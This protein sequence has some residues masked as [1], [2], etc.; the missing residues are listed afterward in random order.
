MDTRVKARLFEPFF[1]TK[2]VGKGT[3]LGL[4]SVYGTMKSHNGSISVYSEVGQGTAFNLY[5][6]FVANPSVDSIGVTQ[7][8]VH[9]TG[10]ILVID[11]ESV[12]RSAATDILTELGY[13]VET[14]SDGLDG[15]RNYKDG[16][17]KYDLVILDIIMP[18]LNGS[19]TF[20]ELKK[21]NPNIKALICSGY[22]MNAVAARI[23]E[24][25]AKSFIQ[26]PFDV[27]K[28][29]KAVADILSA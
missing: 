13:S 2:G 17:Q 14:A 24:N 15:V 1:T 25:G 6:P 16:Y 28:L 27:T 9:G 26:K 19:D 21:I 12:V 4:A 20:N 3:G 23:L 18:K 22:A 10:S 8:I 5:F 7:N 11:D 29:S